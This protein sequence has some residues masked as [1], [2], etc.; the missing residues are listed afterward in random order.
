MLIVQLV[1]VFI[2]GSLQLLRWCTCKQTEGAFCSFSL[3]SFSPSFFLFSSRLFSLSSSLSDEAESIRQSNPLPRLV[4]ELFLFFYVFIFKW[5]VSNQ[6]SN[7]RRTRTIFI[8]VCFVPCSVRLRNFICLVCSSC[9]TM[10][11]TKIHARQIYDSRGNPTVEVD[12]YTE[13]GQL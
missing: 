7:R 5:S 4:L 10:P 12:L 2:K 6:V 1:Y 9:S 11:I 3:L 8:L 13:K